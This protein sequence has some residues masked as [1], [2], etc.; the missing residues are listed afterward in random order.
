MQRA[1][2]ILMIC[3]S[4]LTYWLTLSLLLLSHS[5]DLRAKQ[6]EEGEGKEEEEEEEQREE[7][8]EEEEEEDIRNHQGNYS[9]RTRS[10][11][12]II[13]YFHYDHLEGIKKIYTM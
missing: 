8:E 5:Q 13:I 11:S 9:F 3:K 7:E 6:Q 12:Q 2:V 1:L 4:K 10:V